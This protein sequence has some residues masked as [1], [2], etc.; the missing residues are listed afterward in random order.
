MNYSFRPATTELS[1]DQLFRIAPAIFATEAH[2][3]RSEKFR[4]IPTIELVEGLRKEGFVPVRASQ[5]GSRIPGKAAYT[6]HAV[7]FRHIGEGARRLQ[8]GDTFFEVV[9]RNGNDGTSAYHLN[10]GLFRLICLNGAVV[11]DRSIQGV[12][13]RHSGRALDNV[14]EGTFKVLE[15][16]EVALAAPAEWS[17][18]SLP[19]EAQL[20]LAQEAHVVRFADSEGN[21]NTPIRPDQ[22]LNVRRFD[23]RKDDL[24][25]V[26]NRVQ[27]NA[28]RGGLTA[29]NADTNRRATTRE[30]RGIDQDTRINTRL[31]D[32]GASLAEGFKAAA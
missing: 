25:S 5:G 1:N 13:V 30:V 20:A 31:W 11:S 32:L 27:E 10:A 22:L 8:V 3:S 15:N 23:D 9:L 21:V 28:I 2:E 17:Q 24:W 12:S 7:R 14:I 6:K 19:R 29:W 18:I 4:P 26:W 16:A